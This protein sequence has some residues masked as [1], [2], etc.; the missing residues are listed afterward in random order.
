MYVV[1]AER[2]LRAMPE[3]NS[4]EDGIEVFAPEVIKLARGVTTIEALVRR[5]NPGLFRPKL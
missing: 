5:K 1:A 2:E 4:P 3:V